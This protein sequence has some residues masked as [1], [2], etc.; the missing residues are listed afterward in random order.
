MAGGGRRRASSRIISST[1]PNDDESV[2]PA[3]PSFKLRNRRT[4]DRSSLPVFNASFKVMLGVCSLAF[5]T[6]L[7]MIHHI[8]NHPAEAKIIRVVTPFPAPKMMDLPQVKDGF[9]YLIIC[10]EISTFVVCFGD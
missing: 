10:L 6:I 3:N 9:L 4:K 5:F 2:H 7:F 8:L 1:D